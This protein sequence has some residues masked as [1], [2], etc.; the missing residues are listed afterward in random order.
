MDEEQVSDVKEV[1]EANTKEID[2]LLTKKGHELVSDL[3]LKKDDVTWKTI[4]LEL[5]NS[6]R[7][8]PWEIDISLLTKEYLK[9]IKALKKHDFRLSG[10]MILAAALLLK[11][12]S[13]QLIEG[14]INELD[15]LFGSLH[16]QE[17]DALD[18]TDEVLPLSVQ[19]MG[20]HQ[21][22]P[23]TPQPRKR[24]VSIYDLVDA[25]EKALE[26]K[27]RRIMKK[28]P[29]LDIEIP[30]KRPDVTILM[31]HLMDKIMYVFGK[32]TDKVFF[33]DLIPGENREDKVITFIPL[34]HLDN[35]RRIDITQE[36]HFGPIEVELLHR[37]IELQRDLDKELKEISTS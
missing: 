1:L 36:N 34:L 26:V 32:K 18:M 8:N 29:S 22:I 33:T 30:K 6:S 16:D 9:T 11:L 15:R 17:E 20:E 14:D 31:H 25:L 12:K 13:T 23:K 10:K 35:A 27:E 3:I 5:V 21:L 28:F 7:M 19:N 24:K 2:D 37:D 4:I